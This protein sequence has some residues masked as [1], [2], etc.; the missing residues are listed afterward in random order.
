[1]NQFLQDCSGVCDG[2][3]VVDACNV[4]GGK[5]FTGRSCYN[6]SAVRLITGFQDNSLR[7]SFNTDIASNPNL[8]VAASFNISNKD[9]HSILVTL[10]LKAEEVGYAPDV[11]FLSP[12]QFHMSGN[13]SQE[14]KLLLSYRNLYRGA[15]TV[16]AVKHLS[17]AYARSNALKVVYEDTVT[18]YPP[19]Q[20]DNCGSLASISLCARMPGCIFC[21]T[22]SQYRSLVAISNESAGESVRMSG[23]GERVRWLGSG[24]RRS[25]F[26][27]VV[28]LPL[29]TVQGDYLNPSG[30]CTAGWTRS[31]CS[32]QRIA[33]LSS[34]TSSVRPTS[35]FLSILSVMLL[36]C[37]LLY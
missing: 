28:P 37:F 27:D 11:Y 35:V 8:S 31:A 22:G 19:F 36:L 29:L 23:E 5:D 32:T 12:Q 20:T 14:C 16:F 10:S 2:S 4:C 1:M 25:L 15:Q 26:I 24:P 3:Q 17:V 18:I 6:S 9:F 7:P 21:F 30:F 33:F 13:S 34:A